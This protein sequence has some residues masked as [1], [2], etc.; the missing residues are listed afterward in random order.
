MFDH[1]MLVTDCLW[2][3][4]QV[5]LGP[6]SIIAIIHGNNL[7]QFAS[8]YQ[9]NPDQYAEVGGALTLMTGLCV[10]AMGLLRLGFLE[11]VL[12]HSVVSGQRV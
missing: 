4:R 7:Q 6:E 9:M 12:S 10:L 5:Q 3:R 1:L 11:S 8:R 2:I